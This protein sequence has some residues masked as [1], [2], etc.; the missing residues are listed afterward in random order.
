MM[1]QASARVVDAI[2][3]AIDDE[4]AYQALPSAVAEA[5]GTTSAWLVDVNLTVGTAAVTAAHN[6]FSDHLD[7]YGAHYAAVD[8][9]MAAGRGLT[10]GRAYAM[11]RFVPTAH[12]MECEMYRD[13]ILPMGADTRHALCAILGDTAETTAISLHRWGARGF[14]VE[15]E[16]LL[17]ALVPHLARMAR[18]RRRLATIA[19]DAD[20]LAR[21]FDSGADGVILCDGDACVKHRNA[22]AAALQGAGVIAITDG[23]FAWAGPG[24]RRI[25]AAVRAAA[26]RAVCGVIDLERGGRA[27]RIAIDS[28]PGRRGMVTVTIRDR[29]AYVARQVDAATCAFGLSPAEA[30][31]VLNLAFGRSPEEHARLRGVSMPTVRSQLRSVLAKTGTA[32]QAELVATVLTSAM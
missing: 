23:R 6:L 24:A 11:E 27:Y 1:T 12:F 7:T 30:R 5:F 22:A 10:P 20:C 21:L 8:P 26:A 16:A 9:W 31:L 2:Y 19:G 32:R 25:A 4:Q 13:F 17:Q 28:L 14:E 15:D 18:S 3:D 29:A